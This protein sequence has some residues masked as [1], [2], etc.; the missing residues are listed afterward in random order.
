MN[1]DGDWK[2]RGESKNLKLRTLTSAW[3]LETWEE[4]YKKLRILRN[5]EKKWEVLCRWKR[6]IGYYL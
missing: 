1:V 6:R 4:G 3:T 5:K 2:R